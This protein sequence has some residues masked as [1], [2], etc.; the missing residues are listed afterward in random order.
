MPLIQMI[1]PSL[2][3][4]LL[5]KGVGARARSG[6]RCAD[7]GRTPLTG[8]HIH[9]YDGGRIACELCRQLRREPPKRSE[10]VLG[11]EHG[12]T[13]RITARAA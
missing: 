3:R 13:V 9:F 7:C 11:L 5:R 10:V 4:E 6:R 8:E 12:H 1:A 2:E